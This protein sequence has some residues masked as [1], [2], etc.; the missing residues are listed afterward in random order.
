MHDPSFLLFDIR[1]PDIDVWHDE[2]GGHDTFTVCGHPEGNRLLWAIRHWRHLR[3][4]FWPYLHVKRWIAERCDGCGRRFAWKEARFSYQST[5]KVWHDPCMSLRHVRGQLD[6]LT[7]YVLGT[8]ND[9]ARWRAERRL[10]H[11]E[12]AD[13]KE[14]R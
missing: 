12:K 1:K 11:V 3:I 2:P 10:S 6:D 5:D 14:T 13:S 4:R 8:A 7:G 9:N